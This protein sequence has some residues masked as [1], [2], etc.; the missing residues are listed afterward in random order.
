MPCYQQAENALASKL[1]PVF[2]DDFTCMNLWHWTYDILWIIDLSAVV[3]T[4]THGQTFSNVSTWTLPLA[5]APR[6]G[7]AVSPIQSATLFVQSAASIQTTNSIY[8]HI[9]MM[10]TI[11][12]SLTLERNKLCAPDNR[13][14]L[15]TTGRRFE[16]RAD[17]NW[18]MDFVNSWT[19]QVITTCRFAQSVVGRHGGRHPVYDILGTRRDTL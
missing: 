9:R 16:A 17:H 13:R 18:F 4:A 14:S 11:N 10:T 7:F 12:L 19:G 5:T 3:R 2:T 8:L 6:K 15:S 1:E